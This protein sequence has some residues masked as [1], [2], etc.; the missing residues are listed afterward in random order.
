MRTLPSF[1]HA[2]PVGGVVAP[3]F[4][5]PEEFLG[6]TVVIAGDELPPAVYADLDAVLGP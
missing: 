4:E 2:V 5:R 1:G 6:R 3:I